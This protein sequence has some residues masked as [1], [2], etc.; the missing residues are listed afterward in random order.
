MGDGEN[1]MKR[2]PNTSYVDI[3]IGVQS[4]PSA[5]VEPSPAK[6]SAKKVKTSEE[7][8]FVNLA[9]PFDESAYSDPCFIPT[10]ADTLLLPANHRRL[11][12]IGPIQA[13]KWG[14]IHQYQVCV[15]PS[16]L[17]CENVECWN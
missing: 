16:Y 15:Q 8:G 3:V 12:D 4:I 9:F 6:S 7:D 2:L 11:N 14:I 13:T 17:T 1:K 10:A 5:S